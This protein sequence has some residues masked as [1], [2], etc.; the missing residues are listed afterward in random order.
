MNGAAQGRHRGEDRGAEEE[1]VAAT[2]HVGQPAAGDDHHPEGERVGVDH[3]LD[4]VDVGVEI[5]LHRRQGDVDRREVVGDDDDRESHRE[6]SEPPGLF[7]L[8]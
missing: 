5:A 6:Q 2:E 7:V 4:R 1:G 3:P 8:L